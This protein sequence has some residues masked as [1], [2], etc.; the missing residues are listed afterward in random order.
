MGGGLEGWSNSSPEVMVD[1][2]FPGWRSYS[3]KALT[4]KGS[5]VA[6][7]GRQS[8]LGGDPSA[9]SPVR[10]EVGRSQRVLNGCVA[11]ILQALCDGG[12]EMGNT[13]QSVFKKHESDCLK[14]K[15]KHKYDYKLK[16]PEFVIQ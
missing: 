9:W 11:F 2:S 14:I 15:D 5:C 16:C 3:S 7:W 1:E 6:S 8:C 10:G 4:G 13:I 12:K